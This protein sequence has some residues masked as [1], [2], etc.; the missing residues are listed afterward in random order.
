MGVGERLWCVRDRCGVVFLCFGGFGVGWGWG[1]VGVGGFVGRC[2]CVSPPPRRERGSLEHQAWP[3]GP[4][5]CNLRL[6]CTRL[7]V[8]RPSMWE[9]HVGP[10]LGRYASR[11]W[12]DAAPWVGHTLG[13]TH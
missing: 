13:S 1:W 7:V 2:E 6:I 10:E 9:I 12:Q 3:G 5:M 4:A 11:R 8:A